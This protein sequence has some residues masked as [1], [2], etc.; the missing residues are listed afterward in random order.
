MALFVSACDLPVSGP[1]SQQVLVTKGFID[2]NT[3]RI[4]CRGFPEKGLTGVAKTESSRQAARLN[5]YVFIQS[6]FV[7][8]VAPG[9]YGTVEKY[10]FTDEYAVIHF[11][12]RKKGLRKMLRPGSKT[13]PTPGPDSRTVPDG[14]SAPETD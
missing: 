12:L 2:D 10:D 4:V 13:D 8:A 3:Y 1:T 7:D 5:A 6:E 11:V 14:S 9:R